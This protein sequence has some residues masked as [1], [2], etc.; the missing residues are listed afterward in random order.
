MRLARIT[1][2]GFKS[3]ADRTEFRFDEPITGIV[4]PNG[5]GKSNVV[6]AVKWVLGERSAKSLRGDAMLD[7]IFGGSAARKPLG[8]ASVTLTFENPVVHP[9]AADPTE[10]RQLSVD[11]DEVDVTRR[12]YRDG[13]S[14]YRINDRKCRMRDIKELFMDTGI[15]THAYSIIEQ[16]RVDAMLM[17]NPAERRHI[18]EEAAGV[19]KFKS[20][21]IEAARKLERAEVNLVRVREQLANTERR[22][23]IVKG[24]AR[25]AREFKE[26]DA[27]YR[28][29]RLA[30]ALDVYHELRQNL[31]GMTS[32]VAD[33]DDQ[34]KRLTRLLAEVED[35]KQNA[36]IA[37]A[38]LQSEQREMEQRRLEH[39][40]SR[41]Q[42]M[43]RRDLTE[44]NLSE[45]NEQ[46]KEHRDHLATL[47]ERIATLES[48]LQK[49][50]QSIAEANERLTDVDQRVT[51]CTESHA[52][53]Q[54]EALD[55]AN[56]ETAA[57]DELESAVA[58]RAEVLSRLRSTES[59]LQHLDEQSERLDA[60]VITLREERGTIDVQTAEKQEAL[61]E[62]EYQ[63]AS[64][65]Q[66]LAQHDQHVA[67]LGEQQASLSNDLSDARHDAASMS[68]R[69]H[70]L[71]EMR[72]SREGLDDVVKAILDQPEQ[73]PEVR[74]LLAD[75][76]NTDRQ[77]A[78]LVETALGDDLNLL[79]VDTLADA[80]Q[81]RDRLGEVA[82]RV[83]II[84]NEPLAREDE[85][86]ALRNRWLATSPSV[87]SLRSLIEV[88]DW[89]AAAVD[90]ILTRT[91][92]VERMED[93][94][95][96]ATRLRD[97]R[98][99]THEGET[100][101]PAARIR[102]GRASAETGNDSVG[103]LSRRLEMQEL[104][105]RLRETNARTKELQSRLD[106]IS[107]ESTESARNR[108]AVREQL[109]AARHRVVE[110]Q[111]AIDRL[112]NDAERSAREAANLDAETAELRERRETL[113][114]EK[115]ADEQRRE[116]LTEDVTTRETTLTSA[117]E[118]NTQARSRVDELHE[119]L[120][121]A[122]I[123]LGQRSEQLEAARREYRH[124]ELASDDA[125]RQQEIATQQLHQRLSRVEQFEATI[126]QANRDIAAA[127]EALTDHAAAARE[128][129]ARL[130]AADRDVEQ[131]DDRLRNT[132]E[133]ASRL[134]RDYHAIELTRRELEIKRENL[135]ER[136]LNELEVDL[137]QS[138][139]PY[140]PERESG[141]L[142]PIDR[143]ATQAEVDDLKKQ[144]RK[145]GNVNL[146]AIDEEQSLENRNEEL[147]NQVDDID[148]AVAQL[149]ELITDLDEASRTRFEETFNAIRENFAGPQG[150]FRRL[151]GGGNAD[152]IMVPDE[153]GHVD[154]LES[155]IEVKAKP[156][157]KE[158][159]VLNQLSGG[160]KAMTAVA[161]LM[162]IFRS[163]PSPFCILDEVDAA[164]DDANVDRFCRA[165]DPFLDVSHFI[166]ITHHK[167]TMAACDQL[168][169]VTMQERGVSRRVSVRVE[170]VGSGGRISSDA[171]ARSHGSPEEPNQNGRAESADEPPLI[172][173][174]SRNPS[175]ATV[176]TADA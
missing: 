114:A 113:H 27:R 132:R 32:Q 120:T 90:R 117:R 93:A 105:T 65:E 66:Q 170:D 92:V 140:R 41:T 89:A 39:V 33:L 129:E 42:A 60:K 135:E 8:V 118:A 156:P 7:V 137:G 14:E 63:V 142:D 44:R 2:S 84:S 107:S 88:E 115:S 47:E 106:D 169:G 48:D 70:L 68:S 50:Q 53:A 112:G 13:R 24:Q 134:E 101:D 12:L 3:F 46:I 155:G 151:F 56:A 159:R 123:E 163:K 26:L 119:Q 49:A 111:Y 127:D 153:N 109:A 172:E 73:Y 144:I 15:G 61:Q 98:F 36:E 37:R 77:H 125:R 16:G 17:A 110:I 62:A 147:I 173:T 152:L 80:A 128:L 162:A 103:L 71:E 165:L 99:V 146:D 87:R 69:L 124:V 38:E 11:T 168:Y 52:T 149:T 10:R 116:A 64:F 96:Q 160:E 154:M 136:T 158:P 40:S 43:Q 138:Y 94:I 30:I 130:G 55:A 167:H 100:I 79:I 81:L 91:S 102:L 131:A 5:C 54:D 139:V 85:A 25:K 21:K 19:A 174:I 108:D 9:D 4:G 57:R 75:A 171:I 51:S 28:E 67:S 23:R 176:E 148:S 166:I 59:R 35:E 78:S 82:G 175:P 45:A 22:L 6:D 18:L 86:T 121:A 141:D 150:M 83:A 29:L 104:E 20:R 133:Q 58:A 164:L 34:R 1:V 72:Q 157:G 126:D 95:S 161:L 143:D 76:I 97:W 145:I 74:G 31:E 122:K